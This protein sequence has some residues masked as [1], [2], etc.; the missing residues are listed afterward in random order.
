MS[1]HHVF[2]FNFQYKIKMFQYNNSF[3]SAKCSVTLTYLNV[4]IL[5][6]V[7]KCLNKMLNNNTHGRQY[8]CSLCSYT[9]YSVLLY[10]NLYHVI[11]AWSTNKLSVYVRICSHIV[12]YEVV[13][14]RVNCASWIDDICLKM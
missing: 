3:S 11:F 12:Y 2:N 7:N 5:F 14:V 6:D 10:V 1:Q 8:I 13:T 9:L 4:Y